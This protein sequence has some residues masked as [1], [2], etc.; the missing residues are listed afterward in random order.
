LFGSPVIVGLL[1]SVLCIIRLKNGIGHSAFILHKHRYEDHMSAK[2]EWCEAF[3]SFRLN[4]LLGL[5]SSK[6]CTGIWIFPLMG[7][8]I[9]NSTVAE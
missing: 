8:N 2:K 7:S 5:T 3:V 6:L 9:L 1:H 4:F